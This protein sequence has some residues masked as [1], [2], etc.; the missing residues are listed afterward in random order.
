VKCA[1]R[2]GESRDR[3]PPT[4]FGSGL[5]RANDRTSDR[6]AQ[7]VKLR[8]VRTRVRED[9]PPSDCMMR[10]SLPPRRHILK[11]YTRHHATS[12]SAIDDGHKVC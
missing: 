11:G 8:R 9:S 7:V 5:E 10:P 2:S 3:R 1:D 4:G 6:F 12:P